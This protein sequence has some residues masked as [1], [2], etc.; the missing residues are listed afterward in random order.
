[1]RACTIIARNYLAQARVLAR[2][3]KNHH[4]NGS[5][6]VLVV[7]QLSKPLNVAEDSF[8]V[9]GLG[10]IGL[11]FGEARRMAMIYDVTELSTA[12]KPWLLRHLLQSSAHAVY[13]DPDVEI[14]SPLDEVE[15]LVRTHSI[16]LTPHITEPLPRDGFRLNET[17][18]LQSGIYNL[19]F[20]AVGPGCQP[21][22]DWWS[23]RLRR[24]SIIDPERM[25]FTDQ[26][27]IDF[28]PGLFP[29]F[30]L[31]DPAYNVA[32]WNLYARHLAWVG[33]H[34]EVNGH[35]LRFFHFSGYDPKLPF[36]LSKHQAGNPR[37]R[38]ADHPGVARMCRDYVEKLARAGFLSTSRIDYGYAE[39]P[40]GLR[41]DHQ[42]RRAYRAGLM[43]HE[44][45]G[46]PEPPNPFEP[47]GT[48][49]FVEW[50]GES[51]AVPARID[52]TPVAV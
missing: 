22:L 15:E 7:D 40:G 11:D 36:V 5:F 47:D 20:I 51:V 9:L 6:T 25:R 13:F 10:D 46:K 38:L 2:S 39:S 8:D 30:I 32:Y 31:R 28:V 18:I 16:V 23:E 45:E 43:A 21:F 27:W 48:P 52:S 4:P 17:D 29:H 26:R 33:D 42:M 3:F 37:I 19:G 49:R 44:I 35:P 50:L 14:F 12:V 24:E 34:Y 41:I 1:V